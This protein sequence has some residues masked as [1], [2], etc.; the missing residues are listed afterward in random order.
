[1]IT[2]TNKK[3]LT[4]RKLDQVGPATLRKIIAD[5]SFESESIPQL[6]LRHDKVAKALI[7]DGALAEAIA[8]AETAI[9]NLKSLGAMLLSEQDDQYPQL[10]RCAP[11]HPFFLAYL[12]NIPQ[13]QKAL[14]II[15]TRQPTAHGSVIAE[16]VTTYFSENGWSI[17]SGLALGCDAIAHR[18]ALDCGAHTVAVL[19]HGLHTIAPKS[20]D[21]L[22]QRILANGGALITEFVFGEDPIPRNFATRDKTQAGMSRGVVMIQSDLIGGSLHASRASLGYGRILAVPAVTE[23]DLVNQEPKI[24]A[25]RILVGGSE[26]QKLELLKCK[27]QELKRVFGIRSKADY[28]LLEQLLIQN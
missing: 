4:L 7:K 8:A 5:P 27:P 12:G 24:A 22:A 1:M 20:N 19:A 3:L 16:R 13:T 6:A 21:S 14:T 23:R 9:A 2:D 18:V 15:G 10:L 28:E 17:I 26:T 11:E 25:N